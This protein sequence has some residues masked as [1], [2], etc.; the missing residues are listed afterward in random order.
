[1]YKGTYLVRHIHIFSVMQLYNIH[2][3][4]YVNKFDISGTVI[5]VV[6][7]LRHCFLQTYMN[8]NGLH[9]HT[10]TRLGCTENYHL[11]EGSFSFL[12]FLRRA[13]YSG[14]RLNVYQISSCLVSFWVGLIAERLN[15][16]QINCFPVGFWERLTTVLHA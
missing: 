1:M 10:V 15:V 11:W 8:I 7:L 14:A 4:I 13:Y 9:D 3:H 6:I 12:C 5:H 2:N 16:Y